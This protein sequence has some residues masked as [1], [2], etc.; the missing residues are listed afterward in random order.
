MPSSVPR[1]QSRWSGRGQLAGPEDVRRLLDE[2]NTA[3]LGRGNTALAARLVQSADEAELAA[4][5]ASRVLPVIPELA[6]GLLPWPGGIRRGATVAVSGSTSLLMAML[7][8]PMRQGA[9]AAVVGIPAFGALAAQEYGID[10]SRL[11]LVPSPGPDWPTVV[12]ALIDGFDLVAV[13]P[14]AKV[15]DSTA[16]ALVNRARQNDC[17]LLPTAAAWPGT[18][19]IIGV[20][21][22][23]WTG[24]GIGR[25]RLRRQELTVR[26]TGRGRAA[27]ARTATVRLPP[28]SITGGDPDLRIPPVPASSHAG[29]ESALRVES[30]AVSLAQHPVPPPIDAWEDLLGQ[31]PRPAARTRRH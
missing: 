12:S 15:V 4:P 3:G 24:L 9:W 5:D 31:V 10:L 28:E 29:E 30:S 1:D 16:R 8:G 17:A 20:D 13:A 11:A 23:T 25:G 19:L 22:R 2:V 14:P 26:A 7:A 6:R 18:D 21:G 27:R